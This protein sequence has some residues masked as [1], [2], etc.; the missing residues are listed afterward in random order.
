MNKKI[1]FL[2][3]GLAVL[4]FGMVSAEDTCVDNDDGFFPLI[5]ANVST[6]NESAGQVSFWDHCDSGTRNVNEMTCDGTGLHSE[7]ISCSGYYGD[8]Y[9]CLTVDIAGNDVGFCGTT[10]SDP[11]DQDY[12]IQG[13]LTFYNYSINSED[14][15]VDYCWPG[16]DTKV[17]EYYCDG[18]YTFEIYDCADLGN[19]VCLEGACVEV[20]DT[21]TDSDGDD[22]LTEG[23]VTTIRSGEEVLTYDEC[24]TATDLIE[25][26]CDGTSLVESSVDCLDYGDE[27]SCIEDDEAGYCGVL[28]VTEEEDSDDGM[29]DLITSPSS[30]EEGD[31]CQSEVD[32]KSDADGDGY[33]GVRGGC[34]VDGD[35]VLDYLCGCHDR[36]RDILRHRQEGFD[37]ACPMFLGK[38]I[39]DDYDTL[40]EED[41]AIETTCEEMGG[42]Y[43]Y[44]DADCA[45][46]RSY[47]AEFESGFFSRLWNW[48]TFWS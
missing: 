33:I 36:R 37:E 44:A 31:F 48:I 32:T 12:E 26:T 8:D 46:G 15:I 4:S 16:S 41:T 45:G 10:C 39:C 29:M 34:D 47:A 19:Y 21:C 3:I 22:P 25:K 42:T 6:Y 35:E 28:E 17:V 14:S 40:E 11:D 20:E 18:E 2:L 9:E 27:Y 24:D 23:S 7:I 43:Y 13:N 1:L 38:Y 5:G 30:A